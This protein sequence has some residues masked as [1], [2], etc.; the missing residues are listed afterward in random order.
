MSNF[1]LICT[2]SSLRKSNEEV[3][4]LTRS[5]ERIR[6]ELATVQQ[7]VSVDQKHHAAVTSSLERKVEESIAV[8]A[9][10]VN[11]VIERGSR[12]EEV[13][14]E[15]ELKLCASITGTK[16]EVGQ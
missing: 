2:C 11:S 4:E 3:Q 7:T 10:S 8:S 15:A 12:L 13:V 6:S 1:L 16:G 5:V 9:N 14:R